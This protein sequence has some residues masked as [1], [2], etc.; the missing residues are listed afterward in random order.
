MAESW[1]S[2]TWT[3]TFG[4]DHTQE[5]RMESRGLMRWTWAPLMWPLEI[6]ESSPTEP[7]KGSRWR[8]VMAYMRNGDGSRTRMRGRRTNG[9]G[10]I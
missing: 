7:F 10:G 4:T 9:Y 3:T 8:E 5:S 1:I 6:E 2:H